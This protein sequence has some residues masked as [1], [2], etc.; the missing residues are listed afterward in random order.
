MVVKKAQEPGGEKIYIYY[1]QYDR[2]STRPKKLW[3][4]QLH[5]RREIHE[6]KK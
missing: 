5:T 1:S 2:F 6:R 4:K 3:L